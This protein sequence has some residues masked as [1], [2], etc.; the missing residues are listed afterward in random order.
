[1]NSFIRSLKTHAATLLAVIAVASL[2]AFTSVQMADS[3]RNPASV[4]ALTAEKIRTFSGSISTEATVITGA[5]GTALHIRSMDIE[6]SGAGVVVFKD[7]TGGTT[8]LNVYCAATTPR[9]LTNVFGSNGLALTQN[10]LT[11]TLSGATLTMT[12]RTTDE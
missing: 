8:I 2:V 11:A 3:L 1:M 4:H 7:G 6:S 12:A 5:T 9:E 10:V